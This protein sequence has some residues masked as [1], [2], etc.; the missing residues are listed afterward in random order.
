MEEI[1]YQDVQVY[2]S[3][4]GLNPVEI[5]QFYVGKLSEK[6]D[7]LFQQV[8]NVKGRTNKQWYNGRP[9]GIHTI[10]SFMTTISKCAELGQR[11]TNHCVRATTVGVL[12]AAKVNKKAIRAITGHA[13]DCSLDSYMGETSSKEREQCSVVLSNALAQGGHDEPQF[14]DISDSELLQA[15]EVAT[16]QATNETVRF[17]HA[18]SMSVTNIP[19]VITPMTITG[20]PVFQNCS[21]NF[22]K[23]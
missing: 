9:Q 2:T 8:S 4:T 23:Q 7:I 10:N 1:D 12:A 21:F 22:F 13:N 17:A 11:Y 15:E 3:E 5:Y 6:S 16:S 18:A 14:S 20:N 19:S